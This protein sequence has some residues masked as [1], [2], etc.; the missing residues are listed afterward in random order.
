[1]KNLFVVALAAG[2]LIALSNGAWAQSNDLILRRL[3]ALEQS[4]AKLAG[5]NAGL[6][7]RVRRSPA[8]KALPAR[9]QDL[10]FVPQYALLAPNRPPAMSAIRSLSGYPVLIRFSSTQTLTPGNLTA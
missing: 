10:A 8:L 1:M 6:R 3:D 7:E 9:T 5:E 2:G 4:N